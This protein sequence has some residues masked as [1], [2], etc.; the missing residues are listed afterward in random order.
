MTQITVR[1]V[2]GAEMKLF[3]RLPGMIL[4]DD[5]HWVEPLHFERGQ[6]FSRKHNPWF[7][8]GEAAFFIA[9]DGQRPVGRISAQID[10]LSPEV[11]GRRC[12]LFGALAA[13]NDE[14][15]VTALFAAAGELAEGAR[16]RLGARALY[17]QHQP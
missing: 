10:E 6:F 9:W 1:E 3:I 17:A 12:G 7:S 2:S 16:R 5:P 14:R 4:K 11:E 13:E 8:H 15:I